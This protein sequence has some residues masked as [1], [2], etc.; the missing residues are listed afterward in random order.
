MYRQKTPKY[1]QT[2][3]HKWTYRLWEKIYINGRTHTR[4]DTHSY[5]HARASVNLS[6]CFY[7][8]FVT[9]LFRIINDTNILQRFQFDVNC[10]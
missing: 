10:I 7:C 4:I 8:L 3:N 2:Q 9:F 5:T 1:K 6:T